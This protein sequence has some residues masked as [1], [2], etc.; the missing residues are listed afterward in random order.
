MNHAGAVLSGSIRR[1][2]V[3]QLALAALV[4]IGCLVWY[5]WSGGRGAALAAAFGGGVALAGTWLLGRRVLRVGASAGDSAGDQ[6]GLYAS[7]MTRFIATLVL[8]AAGIGW[9]KLAPVPLIAAFGLAQFGFLVN[10]S[11]ARRMR[12]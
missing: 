4:V 10:L 3:A 8:L 6:I 12:G 5:G 1:V 7:A 11:A 2:L 9:I